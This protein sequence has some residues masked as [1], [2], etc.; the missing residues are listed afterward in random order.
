MPDMQNDKLIFESGSVIC[1]A[2][3]LS[4]Q[5]HMRL[6]GAR[7]HNLKTLSLAVSRCL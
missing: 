3:G 1:W 6:P 5:T 4:T 2:D 7:E